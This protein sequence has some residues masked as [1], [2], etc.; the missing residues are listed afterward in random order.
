MPRRS[1]RSSGARRGRRPSEAFPSLPVEGVP[2]GDRDERRVCAQ[3]TARGRELERVAP[4][5]A[6]AHRLEQL[7]RRRRRLGGPRAPPVARARPR[8]RDRPLARTCARGRRAGAGRSRAEARASAR[9]SRPDLDGAR[10]SRPFTSTMLSGSGAVDAGS[11]R[12]APTRPT[13]AAAGA[14]GSAG[15]RGARR[16][17]RRIG[18]RR[19]V[20][21]P[22]RDRRRL[23]ERLVQLDRLGRTA[24]ADLGRGRAQRVGAR[25]S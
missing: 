15:G 12:A 3:A 11:S 19:L 21:R 1:R 24:F 10:R 6:P 16:W 5:L 7:E 4:P 17:P 8:E 13:A 23:R 22:Q 2:E 9:A 18:L 14:A 20:D 25:G